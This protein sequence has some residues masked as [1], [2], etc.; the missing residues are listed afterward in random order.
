ML[1]VIITVENVHL[2]LYG[3]KFKIFTDHLPLTLIWIKK[4]PRM[5]LYDFKV[6]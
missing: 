2:Y 4:N 5:A 6:I 1:A 3:R